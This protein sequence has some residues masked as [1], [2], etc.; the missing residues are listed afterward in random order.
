MPIQ[1]CPLAVR[2]NIS[3]KLREHHSCSSSD[4]RKLSPY[5][6]RK[7]VSLDWP[8]DTVS[9]NYEETRVTTL[10]G[11]DEGR[12][13][14]NDAYYTILLM[15]TAVEDSPTQTARGH[16]EYP[17]EEIHHPQLNISLNTQCL[18][19]HAIRGVKTFK[20][21]CSASSS[22]KAA[23]FITS[24]SETAFIRTFKNCEKSYGP[25]K[26]KLQTGQEQPVKPKGTLSIEWSKEHLAMTYTKRSVTAKP[27]EVKIIIRKYDEWTRDDFE[28]KKDLQNPSQKLKVKGD[29]F[30]FTL[31]ELDLVLP[32]TLRRLVT[33]N[34]EDPHWHGLE[35]TIRKPEMHQSETEQPYIFRSQQE[36]SGVYANTHVTLERMISISPM[37]LDVRIT[38]GRISMESFNL[39]WTADFGRETLA[40]KDD[41]WCKI[42]TCEY[43]V[44]PR[45][46]LLIGHP[47]GLCIAERPDK[48][49]VSGSWTYHEDHKVAKNL[50]PQQHRKQLNFTSDLAVHLQILAPSR[51]QMADPSC[52]RLGRSNGRQHKCRSRLN[53]GSNWVQKRLQGSSKKKRIALDPTTRLLK[54]RDDKTPTRYREIN[55]EYPTRRARI[56]ARH[57][58]KLQYPVS[59]RVVTA[60]GDTPR[61]SLSSNVQ[62]KM[63]L[64]KD[65]SIVPRTKP[66]EPVNKE[67]NFWSLAFKFNDT[68]LEQVHKHKLGLVP[69]H[70]NPFGLLGI[71]DFVPL[72]RQIWLSRAHSKEREESLRSSHDSLKLC[73]KLKIPR[74]RWTKS[75][76]EATRTAHSLIPADGKAACLREE[77]QT[78]RK[79]VALLTSCDQEE[80]L[81][82]I[83]VCKMK[84]FK[85]H[86]RYGCTLGQH[87]KTKLHQEAYTGKTL[88]WYAK[89]VAVMEYKLKEEASFLATKPLIGYAKYTSVL[90]LKSLLI[91]VV[92]H[93]R[94]EEQMKDLLLAPLS[95]KDQKEPN[96]LKRLPNVCRSA[97]DDPGLAFEG[98]TLT[99]IEISRAVKL[100]IN[101]KTGSGKTM[102]FLLPLFQHIKDQH[103][104]ETMESPMATIMALTCELAVQI[105]RKCKLFLKVLNLRAVAA[106]G[107]SPIK[108]QIA[109]MKKGTEIIMCTPGCMIDLL[110]ANS[111]RVTNLKRVAYLVLDEVDCMFDTNLLK[112][113]TKAAYPDPEE[114]SDFKNK[115]YSLWSCHAE[116]FFLP[117]EMEWI[118]AKEE[119]IPNCHHPEL[120]HFFA[121]PPS[122]QNVEHTLFRETAW[123]VTSEEM[124]LKWSHPGLLHSLP[125]PSLCWEDL[126][127]MSEQD[128]HTKAATCLKGSQFASPVAKR[129][130]HRSRRVKPLLELNNLKQSQLICKWLEDVIIKSHNLGML[131]SNTKEV[132]IVV[133]IHVIWLHDP[134]NQVLPSKEKGHEQVLQ[135]M[136]LFKIAKVEMG[137]ARELILQQEIELAHP[138]Q[139]KLQTRMALPHNHCP[140]NISTLLPSRILSSRSQHTHK[141]Y[142]VIITVGPT[143]SSPAPIDQ[144]SQKG[145][146][147]DEA[148]HLLPSLN[149]ADRVLNSGTYDDKELSTHPITSLT[150]RAFRF[151]QQLLLFHTL[152][153]L[154]PM[155]MLLTM[156][157][158]I[159]IIMQRVS[160]QMVSQH[161]TC[162]GMMPRTP[163]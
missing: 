105:Y 102:V 88:N 104:L 162:E 32:A 131:G 48:I 9:T 35:E 79:C 57:A 107:G 72:I 75:L 44:K 66:C 76:D 21:L 61:C 106:H 121:I 120:P 64:A 38:K 18:A 3:A 87:L 58:V 8:A 84:C 101:A 114:E 34:K 144:G 145:Y 60:A 28:D 23:E 117:Y 1:Y 25:S 156:Q 86:G 50:E 4:T 73:S 36:T 33:H 7:T 70:A 13:A 136:V 151:N 139:G 45:I 5:N 127:Q 126:N 83:T 30:T 74:V 109:E 69:H 41:S 113:E 122:L 51:V 27:D 49:L 155:M 39:P 94:H 153:P 160:K 24:T 90:P 143:A 67:L 22:E 99:Q 132:A 19:S 62:T 43:L 82:R 142:R 135:R 95:R 92:P 124:A 54:E 100:D 42:L 26:E 55:E 112:K 158:S 59:E 11:E 159:W 111:G 154:E 65:Q 56:S 93:I 118:S 163:S 37:P 78:P 53:P 52:G 29:N 16:K 6:E 128:S 119:W 157:Q 129:S 97:H 10:W 108:D 68:P 96:P 149:P 46:S 138:L 14:Y 98:A 137:D 77:S 125:K 80:L 47:N 40:L 103:P 63:L 115:A 150:S 17:S 134:K 152:T 71:F 20:A 161:V 130:A 110:A 123:K 133:I 89:V 141:H 146:F 15:L 2:E 81:N 12:E 147:N 31:A 140:C 116:H 91:L 148:T 85:D